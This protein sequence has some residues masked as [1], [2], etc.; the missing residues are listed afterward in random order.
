MY[1]AGKGIKTAPSTPVA[2]YPPYYMQGMPAM[3][4]I[5]PPSL[6]EPKMSTTPSIDHN[7]SSAPQSLGNYFPHFTQKKLQAVMFPLFFPH[8]AAIMWLFR[9]RYNRKSASRVQSHGESLK[10]KKK[11]MLRH[12]F[13]NNVLLTLS[14]WCANFS[15]SSN[16]FSTCGI[17]TKILLHANLKYKLD[18]IT[19]LQ[20]VQ[21]TAVICLFK[22][23]KYYL[24]C[25]HLC[26]IDR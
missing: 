24:V 23:Q 1:E 25:K 9:W 16:L 17:S 20:Q 10:K 8:T 5:S 3:V 21:C 15:M 26:N 18:V 7:I 12:Y 13:Q 4:P 22:P 2:V 11:K 6:I 19:E 14:N